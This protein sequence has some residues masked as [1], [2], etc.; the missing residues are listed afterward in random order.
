M[1]KKKQKLVDRLKNKYESRGWIILNK[2]EMFKQ[3][4]KW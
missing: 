2:N 3:G 4:L 1:I